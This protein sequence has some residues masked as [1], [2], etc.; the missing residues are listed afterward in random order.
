MEFYKRRIQLLK[1]YQKFRTQPPTT[2]TL[3]RMNWRV[4][5]ICLAII[6]FLLMVSG[7]SLA[8]IVAKAFGIGLFLGAMTI[9]A[10]HS[11]AIVKSWPV[12]D[13]IIDWDLVDEKCSAFDD[14]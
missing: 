11:A 2:W 13:E 10:A 3:I 9:S 6:L 14:E 1:I 7:E 8:L 5:A 12:L 4:Y